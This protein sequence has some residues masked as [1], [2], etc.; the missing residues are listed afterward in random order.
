MAETQLW[1]WLRPFCPQ[2]KYD[3][4]ESPDTS[5]GIPDVYYRLLGSRAG[6]IELKDARHPNSKIP[7][8]NEKVGLHLSQKIWIREEVSHGGLVWICARIGKG[9][10]FVHGSH[11]DRFN[12]ASIEKLLMMCSLAFTM[13]E[14]VP[15]HAIYDL[16][17]GDIDANSNFSGSS[18]TR[19]VHRVRKRN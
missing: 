18:K 15:I 11:A 19:K 13:Q 2:G 10:L 6:W 3:R 14:R 5:P 4:V 7:F 9:I 16:L 1:E 12:G 8:P 17:V